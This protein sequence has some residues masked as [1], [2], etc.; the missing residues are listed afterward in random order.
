MRWPWDFSKDEDRYQTKEV[1]APAQ[2]EIQK[3][4]VRLARIN[5][6]LLEARQAE[7]I[8]IKREKT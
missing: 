8:V 5:R 3:A 7:L 2:E 4:Q 6:I 1:T